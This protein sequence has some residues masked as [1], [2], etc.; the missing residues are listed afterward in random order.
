[1][2]GRTRSG[3]VFRLAPSPPSVN[4]K[5]GEVRPRA[6]RATLLA[7]LLTSSTNS[8]NHAAWHQRT[9]PPRSALR[10]TLM[11][12]EAEDKGEL[13]PEAEGEYIYRRYFRDR[14]GVIRDARKYGKKAWKIP[15]KKPKPPEPKAE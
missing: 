9:C 4:A 1:M 7:G 15:V 6:P 10:N 3:S 12:Y 13:P 11:A 5:A 14:S 2:H 8:H